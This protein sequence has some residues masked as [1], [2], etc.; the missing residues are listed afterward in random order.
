M[1]KIAQIDR[2][3]FKDMS[4]QTT[5]LHFLGHPVCKIWYWKQILTLQHSLVIKQC[6]RRIGARM[7]EAATG[8]SDC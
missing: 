8:L 6:A 1:P 3:V 7:L 2:S 5:S 4:N